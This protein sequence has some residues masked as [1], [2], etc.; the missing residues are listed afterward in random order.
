MMVVGALFVTRQQRQ[1]DIG[2]ALTIL[3]VKGA[4][5]AYVV[6]AAVAHI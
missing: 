3:R 2:K 1:E 6:F 5:V 4:H